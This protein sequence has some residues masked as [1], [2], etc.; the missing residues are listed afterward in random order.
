MRKTKEKKRDENQFTLFE[1]VGQ[2]RVDPLESLSQGNAVDIA[3][4]AQPQQETP[5]QGEDQAQDQEE[6]QTDSALTLEVNHVPDRLAQALTA[7]LTW[8]TSMAA[9]FAG[10][11]SRQGFTLSDEEAKA[12]DVACL[13]VSDAV[14]VGSVST[15]IEAMVRCQAELDNQAPQTLI[16]TLSQRLGS[17]TA[18]AQEESESVSVSDEQ[19][20]AWIA[21]LAALSRVKLLG[22]RSHYERVE[23]NRLRSG[24]RTEPIEPLP[25]FLLDRYPEA[26]APK[27]VRLYLTRYYDEE[28]LLA[29]ALMRLFE[30]QYAV[31]DEAVA[32]ARGRA[33]ALGCDVGQTNAILLALQKGLTIVSGGPGTGKTRTV[34]VILSLLVDL[35]RKA[36]T[37][38]RVYLA[39]PTGK[40]TGRLRESMDKL[41]SVAGETLASLKDP[42][43]ITLAERTLQKWLVTRTA[44]GDMPSAD[45]PLECD[46]L[47]IDEASM[48]DS[49]LASHLFQVIAPTTR[50]LVLGDKHQLEAVGPGSVFADMSD[51]NGALR[52]ST[53]YLSTSHRFRAGGLIDKVARLINHDDSSDTASNLSELLSLMNTSELDPDY[54]AYWHETPETLTAMGDERAQSFFRFYG[55]SPD[56]KAWVDRYFDAYWQ[57]LLALLTSQTAED[58]QRAYAPFVA[59]I[60]QFRALAAQRDGAHS[61]TAINDYMTERLLDALSREG[62][63]QRDLDY[64][65][66]DDAREELRFREFPGRLLIVRQNNDRLGVFN[67]DVAVVL[68]QLAEDGTP[69]Q[70]WTADFM[71]GVRRLRPVLLPPHDTA[72]A[73]TIHQSQGSDF[74]NVGVFLPGDEAMSLAT[75]E[76]LYTGVTRTKGEVHLF[77]TRR[78]LERSMAQATE[79]TSGLS[80][81]LREL[82]ASA[83]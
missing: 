1:D 65:H 67:G 51:E 13:S 54:R 55:L 62:L 9:L 64:A 81:R 83:K 22:E 78:A 58:Y 35:F 47:V 17:H 69:T 12:L 20:Q 63:Y 49:H 37:P 46:V 33:Q 73:M 11:V 41:I 68:P 77:G 56:E 23:A 42:A 48:M 50:V 40:A 45:H 80:D 31:S 4:G 26:N 52:A 43:K 21:R 15:S 79:R 7:Q 61:V 34:G 59:S 3:L 25:P 60:T 29:K 5:E 44:T 70:E 32:T 66:S 75:R 82:Q 16:E 6:V 57:A 18:L 38:L 10:M 14:R 53:A 72:F 27:D 71:D 28:V 24:R 36:D 19:A 39:A 30:K 74:D 8:H 76:L 2:S